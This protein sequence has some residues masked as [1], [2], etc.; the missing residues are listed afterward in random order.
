MAVNPQSFLDK[1]TKS[2]VWQVVLDYKKKREA[3][4]S[5]K[6]VEKER[7]REELRQIKEKSISQIKELKEKAILAMRENGINV[8][9]AKDARDAR[10]IIKE[11]IGKRNKIVKA[12][13][14][15]FSEIDDGD[16]LKD[17]DVIETDLGEFLIK[18]FNQKEIHPVLPSFHL[19]AEKISQKIRERFQKEIEPDPQKIASFVREI[20]RGKMFQAEVGISGA[21]VLT[22]DGKILILENEGNISLTSRMPETHIVVSGFEK[23]VPDLESA[24]KIIEA[25]AIWGTGQDFPVYTSIIAGPS[26][27]ADIQNQLVVGAQGAKD[28]NVVLIDNGRTKMIEAGFEELLYCINCGACLNFCPVFHQM[29]NNYGSKYLGSKGVIFSAFSESLE[30]AKKSNCFSCTLCSACFENC[31]M[32]INLPELMERLREKLQEAGLETEENKEMIEKIRKFGNPF[33][34]IEEDK[35]PKKLYCC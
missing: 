15:A 35:L 33:G 11:I 29:A 22:S 27:T 26:K 2:I 30:K 6:K 8:F 1:E 12:K 5:K 24:L 19:T 17:K 3:I 25:A 13:T 18:L 4:F 7:F 9:E 14:N 28:I 32:K 10:Q 34:E 16:F 20:L 23:I 31:P 21:N